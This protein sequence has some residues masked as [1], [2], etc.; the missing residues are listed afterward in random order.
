MTAYLPPVRFRVDWDNDS[1]LNGAVPSGTPQNLIPNAAY[2]A[3]AKAAHV[4]SGVRLVNGEVKEVDDIGFTR[5]DCDFNTADRF[6]FGSPRGNEGFE[7]PDGQPENLIDFE[8]F[9]AGNRRVF[10][11][12][13]P[14]V[15]QFPN[16][17]Q[18]NLNAGN[19]GTSYRLQLKGIPLPSGTYMLSVWVRAKL[20]VAAT[21]LS[22]VLGSG[23]FSFYQLGFQD[24]TTSAFADGTNATLE[25]WTD[26]QQMALVVSTTNLSAWLNMGI[27][28]LG[29]GAVDVQMAGFMLLPASWREVDVTNR[30]V[31]NQTLGTLTWNSGANGY[32]LVKTSSQ[33]AP[34]VDVYGRI[35]LE[36]NYPTYPI[37]TRVS[38]TVSAIGSGLAG[39]N[40]IR[41]TDTGGAEKQNVG[42]QLSGTGTVTDEISGSNYYV[43]NGSF[44]GVVAYAVP[45]TL[46]LKF[47]VRQTNSTAGNGMRF[48]NITFEFLDLPQTYWGRQ[49]KPASG[50]DILLET[51]NSYNLS[52]HAQHDG[53]GGKDMDIYIYGVSYDDGSLTELYT[54]SFVVTEDR[55]RFAFTIPT[56]ADDYGLYVELFQIDQDVTVSFKAFQVTLGDDPV[57]FSVG[58]SASLDDITPY[59]KSAQWKTGRNDLAD[60]IA[61]EGT[62]N[63][64]L[65]NDNRY[66]SIENEDSP[67]FG[68]LRENIKI[69]FEV[70][71]EFVWYP[72]WAGWI[73]F[74][75]IVAG[76]NSSREVSVSAE[77]GIFRL[78]EG[79]FSYSPTENTRMDDVVKSIIANSGWRSAKSPFHTILSFDAVLGI[80]TYL[81]ASDEIFTTIDRGIQNLSFVGMDWG[82]ETTP[83]KALQEVLDAENAKLWVDRDGGLVLRNRRHIINGLDS[84][85]TDITLDTEVQDASYNHGEGIVNRI[86]VMYQEKK[87]VTNAVIWQS[88]TPIYIPQRNPRNIYVRSTVRFPLFFTFEEKRQRTITKIN[89]RLNDFDVTVRNARSKE[90]ISNWKGQVW[91]SVTSDGGTNLELQLRNNF[92]FA[93]EVD[94]AI[95]GNYLEGGQAQTI[96]VEDTDAQEFIQAVHE[97]KMETSVLSDLETAVSMAK[98]EL[99]RNAMPHGEFRVIETYADEP[100]ALLRIIQWPVGTVLRVSEVQTDETNLY[101]I[102]IAEEGSYAA[103]DTLRMTSRLARIDQNYYNSLGYS[104]ARMGTLNHSPNKDIVKA[105]LFG[106][107]GADVSVVAYNSDEGDRAI[108]IQSETYGGCIWFGKSDTMTRKKVG[109]N[110]INFIH[111]FNTGDLAF[112]GVARSFHNTKYAINQTGG[113]PAARILA[114]ADYNEASYR[115]FQYSPNAIYRFSATLYDLDTNGSNH[116]NAVWDWDDVNNI[117]STTLGADTKLISE[118]YTAASTGSSNYDAA[119]NRVI[120]VVL[121]ALPA[122]MY[123]RLSRAGT[124]VNTPEV[125]SFKATDPAFINMSKLKNTALKENTEYTVS[126]WAAAELGETVEVE[127]VVV[128]HDSVTEHVIP[129]TISNY[130]KYSDTFTTSASLDDT[131]AS[132]F[133]RIKSTDKIPVYIT[134]FAIT[135]QVVDSIAEA[136]TR[137][138]LAAYLFV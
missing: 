84:F 38:Y 71:H 9:L 69:V 92:D 119:R 63:L 96:V 58:A 127:V 29:A 34:P 46:E 64:T 36:T 73:R 57:A 118:I 95:T 15:T 48:S 26:W 106:S 39:Q 60:S 68:L 110:D 41:T 55:E 103:G 100:A 45:I 12:Y 19:T 28:G 61:Y 81:Q 3:G 31:T 105:D 43:T 109:N 22:L 125:T 126:L 131:Q 17:Y 83:D 72:I 52:F 18:V 10:R 32:D 78:R 138:A 4:V 122:P 67:Y 27:A 49:N 13:E 90:V 42:Q 80:N 50:D 62:L 37:I 101:H 75:D 120:D 21:T 115:L 30:T 2:A 134:G 85:T 53:V 59:V 123:V 111:L 117:S 82:K 129:L 44:T 14:S 98:W 89:S 23:N 1:F 74:F 132:V 113:S 94:V 65:N 16:V 20:H 33:T 35:E 114:F 25:V 116:T 135:E 102:I 79:S 93:V 86:Q 11:V 51:G 91:I 76:R 70:Q 107:D 8:D 136:N 97:K 66:F 24:N 128:E 112:L 40:Y 137:Q 124:G 87:E 77:Q 121:K 47:Y 88:K 99:S 7:V 133:F 5:Y 54:S 6:V 130:S 108:R 104:T 56:L